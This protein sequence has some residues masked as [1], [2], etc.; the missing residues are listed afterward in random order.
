MCE[1][2]FKMFLSEQTDSTIYWGREWR[3]L[4]LWRSFHKA[5][6]NEWN[7]F[8]QSP[9]S[10]LFSTLAWI[11]F[12]CLWGILQKWPFSA[13][14]IHH[15]VPANKATCTCL[16]VQSMEL[17]SFVLFFCPLNTTSGFSPKSH[18]LWLF[19]FWFG[20]CSVRVRDS[21]L[22]S[23]TGGRWCSWG[24]LINSSRAFIS[25]LMDLVSAYQGFDYLLLAMERGRLHMC[26]WGMR[27]WEIDSV[28]A[29][30]SFACACMD[31][32]LCMQ[33][34][35]EMCLLGLICWR[36]GTGTR[37]PIPIQH[38]HPHTLTSVTPCGIT[39]ATAEGFLNKMVE[40]QW[41][42]LELIISILR[43]LHH[44]QMDILKSHPLL[45][46][47]PAFFVSVSFW[48]F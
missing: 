36:P 6:P 16:I 8:A 12:L 11:T 23:S 44:Y 41:Q 17:L 40:I 46:E 5:S 35:P 21:S 20:M 26:V 9:P 10:S 37:S 47:K 32:G 43:V 29:S 27:L 39:V 42:D 25:S 2:T 24:S 1:T 4:V 22:S 15:K 34:P 45:Y 13:Y 3:V 30:L 14:Q 19:L 33:A 18:S 28:L 31:V 7:W 38:L 48:Y